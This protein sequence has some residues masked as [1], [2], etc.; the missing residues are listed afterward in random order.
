MYVRF[1]KPWIVIFYYNVL[2]RIEY[3]VGPLVDSQSE[4]GCTRTV[5]RD[6]SHNFNRT[7]NGAG[8]AEATLRRGIS[9]REV[10]TSS[11]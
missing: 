5:R 10:D 2:K 6:E 3:V 4:E 11:R 7:M 8:D 1:V 9:D